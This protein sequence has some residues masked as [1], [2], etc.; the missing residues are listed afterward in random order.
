MKITGYAV[1]PWSELNVNSSAKSLT[2]AS[3]S[4][5]VYQVVHVI[6]LF[7]V[8]DLLHAPLVLGAFKGMELGV[9]EQRFA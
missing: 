6:P 1:D 2:L 3:C 4:V 9:V 5:T 7:R 8:A